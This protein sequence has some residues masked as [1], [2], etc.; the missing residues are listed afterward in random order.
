MVLRKGIE[1]PI[2]TGGNRPFDREIMKLR[3]L[4]SIKLPSIGTKL[5]RLHLVIIFKRRIG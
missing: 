1:P 3:R 2:P 4:G 5:L